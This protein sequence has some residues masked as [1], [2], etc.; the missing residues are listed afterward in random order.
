AQSHADQFEQLA[1]QGDR[2]EKE[3]FQLVRKLALEEYSAVIADRP[4]LDELQSTGR[5]AAW[6]ADKELFD[7]V[8]KAVI[9]VATA[10]SR[11]PDNATS[12]LTALG[13]WC[14]DLEN[15]RNNYRF[16]ADAYDAAARNDP[17][18]I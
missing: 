18:S 2:A 15:Q 8:L 12:M 9:P 5:F 7:K 11:A 6:A 14:L 16:A 3:R 4:T 17:E 1:R 13:D 10:K